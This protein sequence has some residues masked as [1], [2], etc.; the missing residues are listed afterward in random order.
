[1]NSAS[2]AAVLN[3]SDFSYDFVTKTNSFTAELQSRFSD[4]WSNEFRISYVRV[5]DERQPGRT[6]PDG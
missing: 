4:Q 6:F 1:M 2:S 3:S 5:R